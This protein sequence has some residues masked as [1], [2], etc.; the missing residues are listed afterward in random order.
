MAVV[1]ATPMRFRRFKIG[2]VR[3]SSAIESV[4]EQDSSK[5]KTEAEE[6]E[7]E[8]TSKGAFCEI[9]HHHFFN[10]IPLGTSLREQHQS[11]RLG[12][13]AFWIG[14][15]VRLAVR[16]GLLGLAPGAFFR[17][18]NSRVLGGVVDL[19]G[20]VVRVRSRTIRLPWRWVAR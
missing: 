10:E 18:L 12:K 20:L 13:H 6:E 5:E 17:D 16:A 19:R 9:P 11:H 15:C 1:A 2:Y 7:E 14:C 8:E 3:Q 4:Q